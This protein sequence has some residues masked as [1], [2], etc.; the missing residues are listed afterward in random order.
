MGRI[1]LAG[2][3]VFLGALLLFLLQP[4]AARSLLPWY[5]GAPMVWAVSL[6]FFQSALLAGY[7][8][9]HLLATR[10][11]PRVQLA[12]HAGLLALAGVLNL[13][14]I[15]DAGW[16]PAGDAAPAG[17]ILWTLLATLGPAFVAVAATTPLVSA[18]VARSGSGKGGESATPGVYRLY[19]LSNAGSL[20][21]LAL[22]PTV[23]EPLSGLASQGRWWSVGFVVLAL[24]TAVTGLL[25][26]RPAAGRRD[27][28]PGFHRGAFALAAAGSLTLVAVT[29]HLTRDVAAAPLLWTAPLA[30][31]LAT[32]VLAF[33]GGTP[34]PRR[35]LV[36]MLLVSVAACLFVWFQDI[37][38]GL[39]NALASH[40]AAALGFLFTACWI[41]HGE[42][43][44]RKPAPS[45][46]TGFY[47][48]VTAGGALGGL[49][50]ALASPALL[51]NIWEYPL[52][53]VVAVGVA[54]FAQ[55]MTGARR[56]PV[57]AGTLGITIAVS[58]LEHRRPLAATRNFF[59]VVRVM[60]AHPGTPEWRRD[61]W[62]GGIA[63]GSQW[64]APGRRGEPT[65]YYYEGTGIEAALTRHPKRALG[66]PLRVAVV[67]LGAGSLLVH[68]ERGD[69]FRFYEIDPQVAEAARDFF[70]F[71]PDAAASVEVV[72][73]DGRLSL[74][75]EPEAG[76]P[77][78]DVIV[79]DAFA[80]DAIP[81]HLLTA[82]AFELYDRR[83]APGGVIAVHISNRHV[84]LAPVVRAQAR[85]LGLL[86]LLTVSDPEVDRYR[87]TATWVLLSRNADFVT[88]PSVLGRAEPWVG[89]AARP[90]GRFLWTDD[91]SDLLRVLR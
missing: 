83:L 27:L 16:A 76:E 68:G 22:Y 72:L 11:P 42:I 12:V 15:P 5:G 26:G 35:I 7:F 6:F 33:R 14:P 30:V 53:L 8:Y 21:G 20:L 56:W 32:F 13:P 65:L 62:H 79:L 84:D 50:A 73:G 77:G 44:R 38:Y 47:L 58:A 71:L 46:L 10:V 9:A 82:E 1:R 48:S 28:R 45:H 51:P 66:Q 87:Y 18:W 54:C 2:V 3:P 90:D 81:V 63:H 29:T 23:L 39:T 67:G 60:E 25:S 40:A 19:A 75:R 59:G 70:T 4:M 34:Y 43:A 41:A 61:L 89:D 91:Y 55:P 86:S 74:S 37:T 57:L 24:T 64:L 80:G 49:L 78:F 36:P 69:L 17:W 85:R 88:D 52:G 31:Y